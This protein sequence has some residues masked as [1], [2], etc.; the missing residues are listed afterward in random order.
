MAAAY[1]NGLQSNGVAATIK[2]LVA[3]D[4]EDARTAVS[5]EMSE[6]ALRE[7]Y[8]YPYVCTSYHTQ[9]LPTY[10]FIDLCWLKSMLLLGPT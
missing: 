7:I 8:L 10:F 6:R 5:S 2:H 4:Q 9:S 3:N 1:I